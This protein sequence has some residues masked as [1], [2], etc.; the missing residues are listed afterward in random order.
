MPLTDTQIRNA[1][2]GQKAI[3]LFDAGGVYLVI[4]LCGVICA[5]CSLVHAGY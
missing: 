5:S 3:R 4:S 1:R 2:P